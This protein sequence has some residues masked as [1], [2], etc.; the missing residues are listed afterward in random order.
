MKNF[1]KLIFKTVSPKVIDSAQ[2]VIGLFSPVLGEIAKLILNTVINAEA[3][4]GSGQGEKKRE[5][6]TF[7]LANSAPYFA[8]SLSALSGVRIV[9]EARFAKALELSIEV[10]VHLLHA[11]G[12]FE[13]KKETEE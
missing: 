12:Y 3:V 7:S 13:S 6:A 10:V 9:D 8:S 5:L 2:S 4:Y 11:F 1:L